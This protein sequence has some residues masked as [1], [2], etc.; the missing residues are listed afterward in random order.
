MAFGWILASC[1][2]SSATARCA[3]CRCCQLVISI[4][5]CCQEDGGGRRRTSSVHTHIHTQKKGQSFRPE[6]GS[7]SGS[8]QLLRPKKMLVR[9]SESGP[10]RLSTPESPPTGRD[11][12]RRRIVFRCPALAERTCTVSDRPPKARVVSASHRRNLVF[13]R[14]SIRGQNRT[15]VVSCHAHT[16]TSLF[17]T[18]V[19]CR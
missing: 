1:G 10:G 15:I 3:P 5:S 11:S 2:L 9:G 8:E 13:Q 14:I 16:I 6:A 7:I 4:C 18:T 19:T 17:Y 12:Q